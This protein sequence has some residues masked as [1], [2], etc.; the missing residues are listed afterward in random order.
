MGLA[1]E[2]AIHLATF[3][4]FDVTLPVITFNL[5]LYCGTLFVLSFSVWLLLHMHYKQLHE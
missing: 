3:P 5:Q 4:L 1:Q 2:V